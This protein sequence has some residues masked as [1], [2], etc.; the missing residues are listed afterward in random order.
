[1]AVT[2]SI[3]RPILGVVQVARR[4]ADG[5]LQERVVPEGRDEVTELQQAMVDMADQLSHVIGEVRAGAHLLASASSQVTSTAQALSQGTGEQAISVEQ[6]SSSLRQI[7]VT[8]TSFA[9]SGRRSEG[10][11]RD[12]SR[13]AEEGGEAV[14]QSVAAMRSIAEKTGIIEEMAYQ[15]NLLAL[16]AA[17]EAARAGEHGKGFAVVAT[18]VRKLAERAQKA[19]GEIGALAGSSVGIADRSGALISTLVQSIR[20]AA[21]LAGE[22]SAASQAQASGIDQV[23]VSMGVVDDITQRTASAAEELSATAEE[24]ASQAESLSQLMAFFRLDGIRSRQEP[25]A[26][27]PAAS[28]PARRSLGPR[29]AAT[30]APGGGPAGAQA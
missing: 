29:A 7:S 28:G 2:R 1:M 17:I 10:M 8:V 20:K 13:S 11:A 4:I 18:E 14:R 25:P 6:T 9:E 21:D 16:N 19:A 30:R 27:P 24:L 23:S 15:T 26:A 5:D 12:A 22:V 3:T